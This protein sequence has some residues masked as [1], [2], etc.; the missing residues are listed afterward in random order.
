MRTINAMALS[1]MMCACSAT[2][3][4]QHDGQSGAGGDGAGGLGEAGATSSTGTSVGTGGHGGA[5]GDGGGSGGAGSD[6]GPPPDPVLV[7]TDIGPKPT[8]IVCDDE[9]IF[10]MDATSGAISKS[11]HDGAGRSV[12]HAGT[13]G[14]LPKMVIGAHALYFLTGTA[15]WRL[16]KTGGAPARV[17]STSSA[18]A[19]SA[20]GD[21][22]W[23]ATNEAIVRAGG[24]SIPSR[25][26]SGCLAV[27][28]DRVYWM[29]ADD[30]NVYGAL[31]DG[32]DMARVGDMHGFV[33]TMKYAGDALIWGNLTGLYQQPLD[34][35]PSEKIARGNVAS[36]DA[37]ASAIA[38]IDD[39]HIF[40]RG[41]GGELAELARDPGAESVAICG[42]DVFWVSGVGAESTLMRAANEGR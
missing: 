32:T 33:G 36:F 23:Y 34:G 30:G 39:G 13:A 8:A 40:A 31:L 26:A 29:S 11:A 27:G 7:A 37:V 4:T 28:V 9:S 35:S 19:L 41:Q 18:Y 10:W 14:A 24:P 20:N 22:V 25:P 38:W 2:N 42:G 5:D 15:L 1:A 21:E 17:T 16:P 12:L 6:V 3:G